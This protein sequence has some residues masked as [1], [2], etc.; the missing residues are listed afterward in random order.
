MFHPEYKFRP[1]ELY[2]PMTAEDRARIK[3]QLEEEFGIL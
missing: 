1:Q 3:R 2:R